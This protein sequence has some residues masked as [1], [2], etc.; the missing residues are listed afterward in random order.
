[1]R[2]YFKAFLI[3]LTFLWGV[4]AVGLAWPLLDRLAGRRAAHFQERIRRRWCREICRILG[5]RLEIVGVPH[6]NT[7]LWVANH[8]SW[9]DIVALGSQLPLVFVAK[10]EVADWPV[11]GYLA[12]RIGTLF[13]RRGDAEQVA[14]VAERMTWLLRQGGQLMLFPEGTT[15]NGERVLR[16]HA[17]LLR[18]AQWTRTQAQA[19][20]LEYLGEARALAPFVGEDEFLPHLLRILALDPIRL[21]IHYRPPPPLGLSDEKLARTLR[22]Q[23][24]EALFP[25][26]AAPRQA[27]GS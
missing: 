4:L 24:V 5:L 6:P 22:G 11:M 10:E 16:F 1:M 23:V 8:I 26:R 13:V 2:R 21:R 17:G 9:L 14:A 19:A 25:E 20:G 18:P 7:R 12:R 3:A 15:G 27:A